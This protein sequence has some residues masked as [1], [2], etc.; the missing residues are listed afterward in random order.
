MLHLRVNPIGLCGVSLAILLS[1]KG[2]TET[3]SEQTASSHDTP[4]VAVV[5]Y[6]LRYFAER[7]GGDVIEVGF[8]VPLDVDPAFWCPRCGHRPL[9]RTEIDPVVPP[10]KLIRRHDRTRMIGHPGS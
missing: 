9:I 6:P 2:C 5:N 4:Q 10:K 7:I 1:F 8:P 3:P